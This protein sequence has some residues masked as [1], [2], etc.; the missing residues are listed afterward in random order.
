VEEGTCQ[1]RLLSGLT[2]GQINQVQPEDWFE[3]GQIT[4]NSSR[5]LDTSRFRNL[6]DLLCLDE[7][8]W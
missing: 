5:Y 2:E 8:N 6:D 4:S 3:M 1:R 7:T